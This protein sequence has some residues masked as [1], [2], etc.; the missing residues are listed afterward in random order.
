MTN[1][2][3]KGLEF[4]HVGMRKIKSVLAVFVSFWIWQGVRIFFPDL[5][6]H[7]LFM[8]MYCVIEMR[9]SSEKTIDLGKKRI[10][11]TFVALGVGLPILALINFMKS[12]WVSEWINIGIEF[13][14]ILL[15]VLLAIMIAEKVGCKTYCSLAAAIF[16]V[17]VVSQW[18][19][20]VYLYA[21]LRA[22]QTI[23][24]VSV[25]WLIN[26]KLFPY[27]GK[28]GDNLEK[29]VRK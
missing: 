25:A 11:A 21:I 15:G 10:I 26:V 16:I 14:L 2:A 28:N 20:N 3:E 24:G 22:F 12:F 29:E 4:M 13:V 19:E 7:P 18:D 27:P 23:L 1:N 17:I 8:Y 9:D 6:V 5:E